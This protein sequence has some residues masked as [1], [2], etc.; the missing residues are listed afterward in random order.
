LTKDLLRQRTNDARKRGRSSAQTKFK[1]ATSRD[2]GRG[3][4]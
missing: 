3:L 2:T 4:P 1:F